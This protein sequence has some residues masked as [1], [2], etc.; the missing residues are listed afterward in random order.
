MWRERL[1]VL[2]VEY[3]Q[4]WQALLADAGSEGAGEATDD[5]IGGGASE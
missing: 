3:E 5:G 2:L 4:Y 1:E